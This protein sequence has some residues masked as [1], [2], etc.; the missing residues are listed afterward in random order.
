[1]LRSVIP[2]SNNLS[3]VYHMKTK[4]PIKEPKWDISYLNP[5]TNLTETVISEMEL[6]YNRFLKL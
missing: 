4:I 2:G 1:M 5:K 3:T 6:S